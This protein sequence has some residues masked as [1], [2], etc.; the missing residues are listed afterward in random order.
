M[1]TEPALASVFGKGRKESCRD[2]SKTKTRAMARGTHPMHDLSLFD[3]RQLSRTGCAR[4]SAYAFPSPSRKEVFALHPRAES[5][6]TSTSFRI[7]G[8]SAKTLFQEV[9]LLMS[10]VRLAIQSAIKK[11]ARSVGLEIRYAFQNPSITSPEIYAPW[12]RPGKVTCIFDVGAN[13]GQSARAFAKAFGR[14]TVH[15]FE[16]FPAAYARLEELAK[17]SGGRI[18]AYQL[19][20]GAS[21]GHMDVAVDPNSVSGL[22]QLH[23]DSNRSPSSR[24]QTV[25]IKIS[26][27]DTIC[28]HQSIEGI[29]ILKTDTEG[30]DANVLAGAH[31]MLSEGRVRCVIC[32]VGFLDDAQHTDFTNVFLFL[33]Q[34]GFEMAG[35]YES[36]YLRNSRFDFTNALFIRRSSSTDLNMAMT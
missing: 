33:H 17:T 29:D 32:E 21:E 14:S 9:L 6:E 7:W 12:L 31:R 2:S 28:E 16:P 22:N 35:F 10:R 11:F 24:N 23:S 30:Y 19:A 1:E 3:T 26:T 13:V 18:K 15:S 25:R 5:R 34:L 20:C 8:M 4:K 27:I 36:S